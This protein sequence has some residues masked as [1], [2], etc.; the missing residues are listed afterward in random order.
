MLKVDTPTLKA[1]LTTLQEAGTHPLRLSAVSAD[2][3][4]TYCSTLKC[5]S[6]RLPGGGLGAV[7]AV[8][9]GSPKPV[10]QWAD[11]RT[12]RSRTAYRN[13]PDILEELRI[14]V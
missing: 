12:V 13:K 14:S 11:F 7:G 4:R 5:S 9:A 6:S 8:L 1:H 2:T 3:S 10:V